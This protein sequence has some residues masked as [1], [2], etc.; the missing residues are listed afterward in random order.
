[1]KPVKVLVH[2]IMG[3]L[4]EDLKESLEEI[5]YEVISVIFPYQDSSKADYQDP[6]LANIGIEDKV[7]YLLEILRQLQAQGKKYDLI[8]HSA[9]ALVSLLAASRSD[10]Q[11]RK[12]LLLSPV[13]MRGVW[14]IQFSVL[15]TFLKTSLTWKFFRK[16]IKLSYE[17]ISYSMLNRI[18]DEVRRQQIYKGMCEESGRFIF[19]IGFW[20]F[21]KTRVSEP[22]IENIDCPVRI[23]VGDQDRITPPAVAKANFRRLK[24][25]RWG[26]G[27]TLEVIKGG[28]HWLFE[29]FPHKI[30][31]EICS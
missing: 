10:I 7:N 23:L 1:M 9:G 27:H 20:P 14:M 17:E 25:S 8:G 11:P 12:I 18:S 5:G 19:Q 16:K 22:N 6:R 29:E 26:A 13:G 15:R 28:G 24:K 31:E 2:G 3:N 21:D 4:F 30:L